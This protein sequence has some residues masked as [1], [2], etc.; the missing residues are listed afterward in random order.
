MRNKNESRAMAERLP[1]DGRGV[2]TPAVRTLRHD[3][4][5][6]QFRFVKLVDNDERSLRDRKMVEPAATISAALV[7]KFSEIIFERIE[8]DALLLVGDRGAE[9]LR[10]KLSR[11]FPTM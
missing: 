11:A 5:Y 3:E 7:R 8:N 9:F 4:Q 10:R 2:E 6:A 1:Y